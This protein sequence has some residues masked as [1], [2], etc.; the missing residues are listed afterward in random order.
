MSDIIYTPPASGGGGGQNPTTNYIPLND[1]TS[2]FVD[3]NIFN[4][5]DQ[6]LVTNY[7]GT[8]Q[9]LYIEFPT[10]F[11][12]IG[13]VLGNYNGTTV[14]VDYALGNIYLRN[15][16]DSIYIGD[17]DYDANNTYLQITDTTQIIKTHNGVQDVGLKLDFA[18]K[19]YSFGDFNGVVSL[20]YL[21][22]DVPNQYCNLSA[23]PI[24]LIVDGG[25]QDI[26]TIFGG[27]DIGL[28]LDYTI[29]SYYLGDFDNNLNKTYIWVKDA[30]K[31]INLLTNGGEITFTADL[32]QFSGALTSVSAG[33]SSPLGHLMLTING[34]PC[35]IQL[36][37]P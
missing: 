9:G 35:K 37:N 1:G 3:S 33:G 21:Y 7:L 2:N 31:S 20:T 36:L 4:L 10:K 26:K 5:K 25:N 24:N 29:S 22:F 16:T 28:K 12:G 32:L 34:T 13:D 11:I 27:N 18:S 30:S 8:F 23:S 15:Y 14:S 17:T 19:E 6:Q